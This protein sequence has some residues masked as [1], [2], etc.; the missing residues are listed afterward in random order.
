MGTTQQAYG[1]EIKTKQDEKYKTIIRTPH[2]AYAINGIQH[3]SKINAGGSAK[4]N[5]AVYKE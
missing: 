3:E 4:G 5:F 1:Q 2:S